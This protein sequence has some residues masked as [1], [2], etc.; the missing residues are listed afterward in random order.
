MIW[1]IKLLCMIT[2]LVYQGHIAYNEPGSRKASGLSLRHQGYQVARVARAIARNFA[3]ALREICESCERNL[4]E[5]VRGLRERIARE[6]ARVARAGD[7]DVARA[8]K[9]P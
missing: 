3:R 6:I 4:R 1:K 5:K 2:Q 9:M 7:P 8:S